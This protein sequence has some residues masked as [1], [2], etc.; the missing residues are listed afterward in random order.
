MI[1]GEQVL[2]DGWKTLESVILEHV[3]SSLQRLEYNKKTTARQLGLSPKTLLRYLRNSVKQ[4]FEDVPIK[5]VETVELEHIVKTLFF[6]NGSRR[7]SA[8]ALGIGERTIRNKIASAT[9]K[10]FIIPPPHQ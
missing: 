2:E 10:G 8:K 6:F 1:P 3:D 4:R 5:T 7:K 9:A